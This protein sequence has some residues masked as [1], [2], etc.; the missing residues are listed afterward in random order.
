MLKDSGKL[1]HGLDMWIT[2]VAKRRSRVGVLQSM[3]KFM[4][5]ND[6]SISRRSGG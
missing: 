4:G 2:E 6:G 1:F 5:C 3:H